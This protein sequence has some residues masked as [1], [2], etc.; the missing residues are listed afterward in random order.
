VRKLVIAVTASELIAT[1]ISVTG[2]FVIRLPWEYVLLVWGYAI[3]WF[4]VTDRVKLFA[5]RILDPPEPL[6]S[7]PARVP[8]NTYHTS[9]SEYEPTHRNVYHTVDACPYGSAIKESDRE[10]GTAGRELCSWCAQQ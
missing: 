8:A 5:Y 3:A 9:S 4:L 10:D 6:D 1:F 7:S 2:I